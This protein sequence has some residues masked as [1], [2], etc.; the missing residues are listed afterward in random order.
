MKQQGEYQKQFRFFLDWLSNGTFTE[1]YWLYLK[2]KEMY[3]DGDISEIQK[4]EYLENA[5][6]L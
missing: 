2:K 6:M 3:G 5:T 1:D 4:K